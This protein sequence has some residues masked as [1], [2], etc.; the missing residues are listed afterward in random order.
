MKQWVFLFLPSSLLPLEPDV[1]YQ[2]DYQL[3]TTPK[4]TELLTPYGE[5]YLNT[6]EYFMIWADVPIEEITNRKL[7]QCIDHLLD[8]GLATKTINCHPDSIRGFYGYLHNG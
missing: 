7:L 4:E 8:R 6:L 3:P 5:N 1:D 2:R